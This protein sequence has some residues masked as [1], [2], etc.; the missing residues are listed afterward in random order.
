MPVPAVLRIADFGPYTQSGQAPGNVGSLATF[1]SQMENEIQ[2]LVNT[3][4]SNAIRLYSID[5]GQDQIIDYAIQK[6]LAVIPS[7]FL[8]NPN[9]QPVGGPT[10]TWQQIMGDS[11]IMNELNNFV[12]D[13]EKLPSADF[14]SIPFVVIGNE[15]IS[16]VG[17][18]NEGDIESAIAYVKSALP[19]SISSALKFT[20][21]ETYL[22]QYMYLGQDT[23]Y[24]QNDSSS[25]KATS[26]G[27]NANVDV[28][29]ANIHP[30]WDRVSVDQA[31]NRV[32][33]I[34]RELQSLYPGKE[35]VI[36]ETGWP[37]QGATNGAA[38][39]SLSNENTF[40]TDFYP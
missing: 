14:A 30:Y 10:A 24:V 5:D 38:V 31:A 16:E 15:E 39:P 33:Q 22:G 1:V 21:A 2:T 36:S 27:Q 18:W 28:I 11:S 4:F 20:T 6:G 40:W 8:S 9:G 3:N 17:G 37:S 26:L 29:F 25:Y 23:G 19:I 12:S 35:V 7:V 13:L 32:D 34:Y